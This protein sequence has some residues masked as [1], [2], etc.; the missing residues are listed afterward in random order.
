MNISKLHNVNSAS[1]KSG[2]GDRADG[3][4][5]TNDEGFSL[6]EMVVA[7][8][9]MF[10]SLMASSQVII[11]MIKATLYSRNADRAVVLAT[12]VMETAVANDCGGRLPNNRG[13]AEEQRAV[14]Q[15][16]QQR[17]RYWQTPP[18]VPTGTCRTASG[19]WFSGWS[20]SSLSTG[21]GEDDLGRRYFVHNQG[22]PIFY[23]V[24]YEVAWVPVSWTNGPTV[25]NMRLRR[26][27]TVQWT[28]PSRPNTIR[29][30]SYSQMAALSPDAVQSSYAGYIELKAPVGQV[31]QVKVATA[32]TGDLYMTYAAD[33]SGRVRIPFLPLD[34][35]TG[36]GTSVS[37]T[38]WYVVSLRIPGTTPATKDVTLTQASSKK[39][40][41][42]SGITVT[43]STP[44]VDGTCPP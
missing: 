32:P 41:Q 37:I 23:C 26:T 14:W 36:S 1:A 13:T 29:E 40:L 20:G 22:G 38:D 34:Q 31:V 8:V 16:Q 10:G 12:Q 44:Q 21:N 6:V 35:T 19:T 24:S 42:V 4:R 30:R 3:A 5:S 15:N 33:T 28:E 43:E 2:E 7:L 27:V 18:T 9:I 11:S 25:G 39:C 17:C